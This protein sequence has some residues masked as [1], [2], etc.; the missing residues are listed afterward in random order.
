MI[1]VKRKQ[2]QEVPLF[3]YVVLIISPVFSSNLK[4]GG[5]SFSHRLSH[6]KTKEVPSLLF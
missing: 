3:K 1:S 4:A 5:H 6:W 2:I